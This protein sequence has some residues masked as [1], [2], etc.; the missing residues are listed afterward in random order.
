[1]PEKTPLHCPEFACRKKFTS[2]SWQFKHIKLHHPEHLQA[3][4]NLTVRSVPRCVEP[5][6]RRELN[7]FKDSVENMDAFPYL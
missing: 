5:A 6:Q 3:A 1:M 4:K 2:D 7:A